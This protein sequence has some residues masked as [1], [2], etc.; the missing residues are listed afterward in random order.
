M[1]SYRSKAVLA[2]ILLCAAI[3][4]V[5]RLLADPRVVLLVSDGKA[6]WL[7]ADLPYDLAARRDPLSTTTFTA[8]IAIPSRHQAIVLRVTALRRVVIDLDGSQIFD[9]GPVMETWK[10]T[11]SAIIP[12]GVAGGSHELRCIVTNANGPAMLRLSCPELGLASDPN[13]LASVDG[14]HWKPAVRADDLWEPEVSENNQPHVPGIIILPFCVGAFFGIGIF[15]GFAAHRGGVDWASRLRWLLL[16][17]WAVLAVNN[18]FK[19]PLD[20]GYDTRDHYDYI[21]YVSD[22]LSLPRPDAGWQ[23]F[24]SPL[25]YAVSAALC[26]LMLRLGIARNSILY[27]LRCVPLASGAVILQI[28]C[29]AGRLVFPD[30]RDLQM[31]TVVVGGLVPMN[32]YMSQTVSNE[33]LAGAVG[34]LVLLLALTSVVKPDLVRS[35]RWLI[36]VGAALGVAW[37]TKISTVIWVLPVGAALAFALLHQ[38]QNLAGWLRTAGIVTAVSL[39]VSSWLFIRNLRQIGT[40]FY[41]QASVASSQWWQYPGY[42]TPRMLYEF[43]HVFSDPVHHMMSS[44]WDALYA[45]CWATPI[46]SGDLPWNFPLGCCSAWLAIIPSAA[47]VA[48]IVKSA[49]GTTP[50][51]SRQPLRLASFTMACFI[52]ATVYFYLRLPIYCCAK[53]SYMLGTAP[54]LGLLAA[55]GFD[56][57]LSNRWL[58]AVTGGL[59]ACWAATAYLTYFVI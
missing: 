21:L 27:L 35:T 31:I 38:K 11:R 26:R 9:S 5:R 28:S 4:G 19:V 16:I 57:V 55:A 59:I 6:K 29:R 40:L 50:P 24:Q 1:M 30:R 53:A 2:A 51:R 52:A 46:P 20:C 43:G 49:I 13:W 48:G 37:L 14:Q 7:R 58:R 12:A 45:T 17:G 22:H 32:L 47:C 15:R 34:A 3:V 44:L 8:R 18:M 39:A 10:N 54:C 36:L 56:G 23:F 42:R 41:L 25:Y 33:P